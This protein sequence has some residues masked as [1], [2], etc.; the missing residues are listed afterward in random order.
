MTT[1]ETAAFQNSSIKTLN[2][3]AFHSMSD[4]TTFNLPKETVDATGGQGF[5][6]SRLTINYPG[7]A[8]IHSRQ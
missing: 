6:K 5:S 2:D 4:L 8:R 7:T 1:V 3:H